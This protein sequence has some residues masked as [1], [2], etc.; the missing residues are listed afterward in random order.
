M[1]KITWDDSLDVGVGLINEQHKMLIQKLN[2]MTQA[3]ED[4]KGPTEIARTLAFLIEY[5]DFHFSTEEK[6][7]RELDYPGLDDH[8]EKHEEF[9]GT[10]A[11]LEND[12][13]E[14][15][16]T[17]LLAESIDTFLVNWL[18]SHISSVDVQFGTFLKNRGITLDGES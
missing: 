2:D 18:I 12:Y 4:S 3:I 9:K 5:T 17:Q 8:I 11:N 13:R 6:H 10:L 16:A 1:K 14:E 7:M 15:G